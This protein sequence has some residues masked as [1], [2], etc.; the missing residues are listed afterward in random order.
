MPHGGLSFTKKYVF[1][2][3]GLLG[4]DQACEDRKGGGDGRGTAVGRSKA[5]DP[6]PGTQ[7]PRPNSAWRADAT[8]AKPSTCM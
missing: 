8:S 5:A 1:Q 7:G 4:G 2:R 6:L 3:R